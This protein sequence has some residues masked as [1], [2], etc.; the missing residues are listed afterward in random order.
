MD[1]SGTANSVQGLE[2]EG[3]VVLKSIST[4]TPGLKKEMNSQN[5]QRDEMMKNL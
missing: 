1:K 3:S 4:A 2:E 5:P